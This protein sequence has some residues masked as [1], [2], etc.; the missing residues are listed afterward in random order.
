MN[1]I[2]EQLTE[3]T[4]FKWYKSRT[5]REQVLVL[6]GIAVVVVAFIGL[7]V[8]PAIWE[9]RQNNVSSY[10]RLLND[11]E[12]MQANETAARE[13]LALQRGTGG[14][15]GTS[16]LSRS[17]NLHNVSIKT[18]QEGTDGTVISTERQSFDD[19]VRWVLA[20]QN[21]YGLQLIQARITKFDKDLPMLVNAQLTIR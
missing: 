19:V 17:A 2:T 16:P 1:M 5:K 21:D 8:Y 15:V 11:F 9:F 18:I 20:L 3:S 12:W 13:R 14:D 10:E 4:L 6:S 7:V